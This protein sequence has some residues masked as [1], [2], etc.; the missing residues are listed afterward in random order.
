MEDIFK[1]FNIKLSKVPMAIEKILN[2]IFIKILFGTL[3]IVGSYSF[4]FYVGYYIGIWMYKKNIIA[5]VVGIG[6]SIILSCIITMIIKFMYLKLV[7]DE[8]KFHILFECYH[9]II[10]FGSVV[11]TC[12][13]KLQPI[14]MKLGIV[15]HPSTYMLISLPIAIISIFNYRLCKLVFD[16]KSIFNLITFVR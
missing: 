13:I 7:K 16:E 14:L 8:K 4:I 15:F 12:C 5:F 9:F 3:V 10:N 11:L 1:Y 2:F 6:I